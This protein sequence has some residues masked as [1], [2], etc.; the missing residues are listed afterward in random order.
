MT[1]TPFTQDILL[2][3]YDENGLIS[4]D[5]LQEK[6]R[7]WRIDDIK[8]R[9]NQWRFRQV[10]DYTITNGEIDDFKFLKNKQEFSQEL[11]EGRKLKLEEYFKQVTATAEIINKATA[12]DTNRLK[13]IQLQQQALNE[14]PDH[15]FKELYEVYS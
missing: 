5:L 15:Y 6:L 9:L 10:I 13:A 12:S 7:G 14:I 11:T 1:K 8:S 2:Q 4:F 3:V